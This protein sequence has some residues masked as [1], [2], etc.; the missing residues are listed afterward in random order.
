[1]SATSTTPPRTGTL[2]DST[3]AASR[4]SPGRALLVGLL[5]AVLSAAMFGSSGAVAKSAFNSGWSPAAAVRQ[6]MASMLYANGRPGTPVL[7]ILEEL[8]IATSHT[9]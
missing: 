1:M 3:D 4:R 5:I 8:N 6:A 7:S 2:A 9:Q